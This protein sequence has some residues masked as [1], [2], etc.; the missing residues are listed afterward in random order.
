MLPLFTSCFLFHDCWDDMVHQLSGLEG[1]YRTT[2]QHIE[3]LVQHQ[4]HHDRLLGN[5]AGAAVSAELQSMLLS[6]ASL[7]GLSKQVCRSYHAA[8]SWNRHYF[9]YLDRCTKRS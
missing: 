8:I 4:G 2:A 3:L 5:K 6:C 9:Y 7:D 1:V